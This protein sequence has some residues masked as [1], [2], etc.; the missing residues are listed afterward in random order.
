MAESDTTDD[1]QKTEDPTPKKLEEA[2]KKGQIALSRE[3][4]NWVMLLAGTIF[5]MAF[6]GAMMTEMSFLLKVYIEQAHSLPKAPGGLSVI[7]GESFIQ[8]F[9]IMMLPLL[10]LMV[11]AFC[12]PFLQI[13]PLFAPGVIKPDWSK[14]SII[15]GFGRLFSLRSIV[16]FIKGL[17]KILIVGAVATIIIMPYLDKFEHLIDLPVIGA[18]EE[19]YVLVIKMMIGILIVV[20][21]IAGIDLIY[22][23]HE[24][25]KKMRMSRQEIKDEYKQSEGD[26]MIK[27][28]LRQLRQERAR[29]RIMQAVPEADVVITNP[30]HFSIALKYNP[31]ESPAP[32]VIAKGIDET[33]LRIREVAKEND[34]V[35][36][37]NKPLA[38]ALYDVA[39][40][41][42]IIPTE[43]F[44]AV[45]EI[46]SYVFKLKGKLN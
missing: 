42:E 10:L 5:L 2:R 45:A 26:P 37:E 3:V 40:I 16:E 4:N 34:I 25:M 33:A 14:V 31:D 9:K 22:Q 46:I 13:G 15:K 39:E 28:R 17:L 36:Y 44:K 19:L 7:L 20:A 43:H 21:I 30:T 29:Q 35:L 18:M 6:A 41:D 32:I 23:R 24:Y 1:S 38:R 12:A 27:G 11:A 8:I